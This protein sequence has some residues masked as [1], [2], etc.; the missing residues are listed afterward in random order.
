M[1]SSSLLNVYLLKTALQPSEGE[2]VRVVLMVP[3]GVGR[4]AHPSPTR[5]LRSRVSSIDSSWLVPAQGNKFP[6]VPRLSRR[7]PES[8]W[9]KG[10]GRGSVQSTEQGRCAILQGKEARLRRPETS[11]ACSQ[12]VMG[13]RHFLGSRCKVGCVRSVRGEGSVVRCKNLAPEEVDIAVD[14]PCYQP[15]AD[16]CISFP[17]RSYSCMG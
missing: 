11:C 5:I 12:L 14:S 10:G 13:V 16:T 17:R 15:K 2:C 7:A 1:R 6:L 3:A 4:V 8:V 9:S